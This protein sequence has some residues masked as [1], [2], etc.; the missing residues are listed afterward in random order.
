M[1]RRVSHA[2][3]LE[4]WTPFLSRHAPRPQYGT[5]LITRLRGP[6][7]GIEQQLHD[8]DVRPDEMLGGRMRKLD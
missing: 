5:I 2:S 3:V 6:G 7:Y 1:P 8:R 4:C